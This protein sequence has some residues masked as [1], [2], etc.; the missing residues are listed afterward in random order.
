LFVDDLDKIMNK[1]SMREN[2]E[3]K[4]FTWPKT[5]CLLL[6]VWFVVMMSEPL[7]GSKI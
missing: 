2:D 5:T 3:V 4:Y 1:F 6:A 7:L